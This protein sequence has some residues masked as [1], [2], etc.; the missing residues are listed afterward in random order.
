MGLHNRPYWRDDQGSGGHGGGGGGMGMRPTLH[1][2]KPTRVTMWLMIS[3]AVVFVAQIF[4]GSDF[5]MDFFRWLGVY[6]PGSHEIWRLLTFQFI[7]GGAR[8]FMWNMLGLYFFG[9][10]VEKHLGS[11]KFLIFYLVCGAVGGLCFLAM[12]FIWPEFEFIPLVG[13]SGGVLGCLMGC[14]ILFPGFTVLIFPI[15]WVAAFYVILYILSLTHDRDLADAAH[16]GGMGAAAAWILLM[17]RL[18]GAARD[19]SLKRKQGA[20]DRK[21]K[22]RAADQTE[23]DRIL[24]KIK[25]DGLNSLTRRE[26]DALKKATKR[27]QAEEDRAHRL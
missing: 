27:Q 5:R 20:W 12:S 19:A 16:L 2:P 26:K 10:P 14:A 21:M 8:H 1:L 15:R 24:D 6:R 11:K 7:H 23:I 17:P 9:P 25:S 18:R 3:C 4:G 22:Q 13:A